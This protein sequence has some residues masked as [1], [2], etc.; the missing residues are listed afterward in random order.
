M[1]F[2][3]RV[4]VPVVAIALLSLLADASQAVSLNFAG[5]HTNVGPYYPGYGNPP[6]CV[7]PWRTELASNTFAVSNE[8]PNRYYGTAGYALFA[9]YFTYPNNDDVTYN[10]NVS[11]PIFTAN[12][13]FI[14][15]IELPS[16]VTNSQILSTR[17]AAG[18]GYAIIDDPALQHGY[19]QWTFD[20]VNYPDAQGP[21][22]GPDCNVTG[23]VP[24]LKIGLLDG[25]DTF[26]NNPGTAP[27]ARWG[28]E[29][30]ANAPEKFRVGV[31][32]DGLNAEIFAAG[33]VFLTHAV[34][35]VPDVTISSG[36]LTRDRFLDMHFFDITGAQAGDQFIFSAKRGTGDPG[37]ANAGISG[38]TFDVFST[39]AVPGDYNNDGS[40]NT[41][42]YTVWRDHLGSDFQ[43][44]NEGA[45][46]TEG[47]VTIE[48]YNFWKTQFVASGGGAGSIGVPEP[49]TLL[50]LMAGGLG[51]SARRHV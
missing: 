41:A 47:Q 6:C 15:K 42:D 2:V 36:A 45:G 20:G 40:V 3:Q 11:D 24:Y 26:G 9:T 23:G 44:N 1:S 46:Q 5:T 37:Y 10:G 32:T 35:N 51:L 38:F 16:F 43:L 21:C 30:G 17:K 49:C 18:Y 48:D 33:E 28:F 7:V 27:S 8:A 34:G 39:P 4:L 22:P 13:L 25:N 14:D 50:L 12:D 19:R 31:M 29:V